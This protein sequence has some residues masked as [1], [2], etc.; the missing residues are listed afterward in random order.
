MDKLA[1]AGGKRIKNTPKR[2]ALIAQL[3]F[4]L[5][6]LSATNSHH[7]FE[8]ICRHLAR[9]AI[10]PNILP[11][12]GPV[13]AGGDGGRDFE[14]FSTFIRKVETRSSLFRGLGESKP[15]VFACSITD[16]SRIKEKI[17][18]DLAKIC[19][20]GPP[21]I[22][23]FFS[24]QNIPVARRLELQCEC[25]DTYECRLEILDAQA[26]AEQFTIPALFWIAEEYL[27]VSSDLLPEPSVAPKSAYAEARQ[28]WIDED[29]MPHNFADFVSVKSGLRA[30]AFNSDYKVDL[31]RWLAVMEKMN[32]PDQSDALR[33]RV[34]YELCIATL[35]GL[36]D[37]RPREA[38]VHEYLADWAQWIRP[39]ELRDTAVFLS[40]VS[41]AVLCRE[42]EADPEVLHRY[43]SAVIG[44]VDAEIAAA[45]RSPN[46]L[47]NLLYTRASLASLPFLTGTKPQYDLD[48][49][50]LCWFKLLKVADQAPLF[51]LESF[52]DGLIKLTP[53]LK[54]H[55]QFER[56]ARRADDVLEKRSSGYVVAEK[57]RDRAMM[58]MEQGATLA[59]MS[60]LHRVKDKW[61]NG[62]TLRPAVLAMLLISSAYRRLGLLWAGKYYALGAAF[63]IEHSGDDDLKPLFV[64]ALHEV[65]VCCYDA[66]EWV[67]LSDLM[68]LILSAHYQFAD[69]PDDWEEHERLQATIYHFFVA[70][71]LSKALH[72]DAVSALLNAPLA[73][74]GMP[75]DLRK[76]LLIPLPELVR[77]ETLGPDQIR[78]NVQNDLF[79]LPLCDTGPVRTYSWAALG[80]QW[81]VV[82]ANK[83]E[84]ICK[85]EQFVAI[86]QIALADLSSRDLCLLPTKV[87][88]AV[89]L[90]TV[91][92]PKLEM[93]PGNDASDMKVSLPTKNLASP[94]DLEELQEETCAIA[95]SV[96]I[97]CSCLSDK[98]LDRTL[99]NAF[100]DGLSS[101]LFIVRPYS[102]I[103]AQFFDSVDFIGRRGRPLTPRDADSYIIRSAPELGWL[104]TPGPGYTSEKAKVAI[105]NR[106]ERAAKPISRTLA[107]LRKI[108]RFK[109]WVAHHRAKGRKDWWILLLLMNV[110][111]NYRARFAVSST[112]V[113]A[114]RKY[115]AEEIYVDEAGDTAEFPVEELFGE[116]VQR[117]EDILALSTAQVWKLTVRTRTPDIKAFERLI[118]RRYGQDSD[119]VEHV[120]PFADS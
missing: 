99:E 41:S 14:T 3:L 7:E 44:L 61:F 81:R 95:L 33:R 64:S 68:P 65:A 115:I 21:Y 110:V 11:A 45:E 97:N 18:A 9:E 20:N 4:Q 24:N 57:C 51:E 101:K 1:A 75:D 111:I 54:G 56:L 27:H 89:E 77:F 109:M 76:D 96:L 50:I 67:S 74:T 12:T 86:L 38:M 2:R 53:M 25:Q 6:Q 23:Y 78:D 93:L 30:A 103:F 92:R 34:K 48:A 79:G 102:E 49:T 104:D 72:G 88:I 71:A 105:N 117:S 29:R 73:A 118:G 10:T 62:D 32:V 94:A 43:S 46:R 98:D 60:E 16:K 13:T 8:H 91:N 36:H 22:V 19:E 47:A 5:D 116:E 106:Y 39:A 59:G 17:R 55:P 112:D 37:L 26:I 66:G 107:R 40:Y 80:I 58:L 85:V 52:V 113:N 31:K 100:R 119:D 90:K 87:S 82:C 42:F 84:V 28:R 35:R 114:L 63:L 83:Y 120:D 69:D 108:P 70:R 15:L